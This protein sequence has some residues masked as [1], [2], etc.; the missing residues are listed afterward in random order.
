MLKRSNYA[1]RFRSRSK[2]L[3]PYVAWVYYMFL[4]GIYNN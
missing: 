4:G 3:I 1:I 2:Q